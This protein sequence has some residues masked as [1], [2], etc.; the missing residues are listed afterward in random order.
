MVTAII[1]G[2]GQWQRYTKPLLESIARHMPDMRVTLVDNGGHYAP[3]DGVQVVTTEQVVSYPAAINAGLSTAQPSDWYLILNNDI[4]IE[5]SFSVDKFDRKSL[6][7]FIRYP[8]RQFY[9]LAGWAL[10]LPYE[11]L[12]DIG[13]FDEQ[14]APMWFED[15]DYCIRAVK[16]GYNLVTLDRKVFGIRHFEDENMTERRAYLK[17]HA[18]ARQR[19][20]QYVER[21]HGIL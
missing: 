18:Q 12:H 3:V 6:Y 5:K 4:L 15:A 11:A 9:Y 16:A 7:G 19:N 21:K 20:R 2:V 10:F 1:V 17:K 13:Y 14:L 8:F